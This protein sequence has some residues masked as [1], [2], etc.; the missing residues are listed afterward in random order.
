MSD[1]LYQLMYFIVGVGTSSSF[2][3]YCQAGTAG[4][5][6]N[7]VCYNLFRMDHSN[8]FFALKQSILLGA[9]G[10]YAWRG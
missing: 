7:G 8:T 2:Y 1:C 3:K 9:P 10:M 4:D 5:I 6:I